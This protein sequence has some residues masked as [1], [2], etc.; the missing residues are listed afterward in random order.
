M[1]WGAPVAY[2]PFAEDAPVAP[3]AS[4]MASPPVGEADLMPEEKPGFLKRVANAFTG[5]GKT[6][7]PDAPEFGS[8]Y[9]PPADPNAQPWKRGDP[10][11][12][13]PGRRAMLTSTITPDPEAQFDI[14][15]KAIPGLER[16]DDEHGNIM[17]KAPGMKEFAYLNKPGV[18]RRDMTEI[19][20]QTIATLPAAGV[21][22]KGISTLGRIGY[23]ML[24]MGTASVAQ[25][26]AAG[27]AGSEQGVDPGRAAISAGIGAAI[28]VVGAGVRGA[29]GA[30]VGGVDRVKTAVRAAREPGAEA[31][32]ELM[33][34]FKADFDAGNLPAI[35][36]ADRAQAAARGQELRVMDFGGE[37]V[38][39]QARKAANVSP[40]ARQSLMRVIT[41]RWETQNSRA[42]NLVENEMGFTR[43]TEAAR[44]ALATQARQARAPL[45]RQAYRMG[46]GGIDSPVLQRMQT[47]P[48]FQKAMAVAERSLADEAATPGAV[49]YGA[50]APNGQ[51]TLEFWDHV[52]RALDDYAGKAVK[53]KKNNQARQLSNMARELRIHLDAHVPM[54]RQARGTA[55]TFF[56][57][58]NALI[59]GRDFMGTKRYNMRDAEAAVARLNPAE[60]NLFEEGAADEFVQMVRGTSDRTQL[61]NRIQSSPAERDR[62][63]IAFGQQR[64]DQ[65]EAFLRL[66]GLMDMP[67]TAMGNSTTARQFNEIGQSYGGKVWDTMGAGATG[68]GA[69]TMDPA[70]L[71]AG[72]LMTG[73][74]VAQQKVDRN[75]ANEMAT[76]LTSRDPDAFLQGM[77]QIGKQPWL[78]IIR[79]VDNAI[80]KSGPALPA[81]VV[82]TVNER[83][84]QPEPRGGR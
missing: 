8:V 30:I 19:G 7:Y 3:E 56:D 15:S 47:S 78:D 55:A 53:A 65:I 6:Q 4:P 75:V 10:N 46:A 82:Q 83:S 49:S 1:P 35:T 69:V 18:S 68:V 73:G 72:L 66:E 22:A 21:A 60:R 48:S 9:P 71:I 62:V 84:Y 79:A 39:A 16:F 58:D 42:V 63:R 50:Q 52:K 41:P 24:G 61:L 5:E 77:Q 54:Y 81:A 57:A 13:A 28:P 38:H 11:P 51:Y 45:Y 80:A 20:A 74:K 40:A 44:E 37:T 34:A 59:A 43:S 36:A 26:V 29:A 76:L 27:A 2:D 64:A 70:A 17:L 67:R 32:R 25:D 14:L 12:D 31:E 33:G 23:G